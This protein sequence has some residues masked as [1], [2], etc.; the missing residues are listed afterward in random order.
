MVMT[1][2]AW[3]MK[4]WFALLLPTTGRR[5]HGLLGVEPWAYLKAVLQRIA[6]GVEPAQLT[7]RL[8]RATRTSS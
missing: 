1:S 7:P 4:A 2:L 3:S 6:E 5:R 8:W